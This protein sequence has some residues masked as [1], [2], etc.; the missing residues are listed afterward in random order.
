[1]KHLQEVIDAH[2]YVKTLN[3][4]LNDIGDTAEVIRNVFGTSRDNALYI[5]A[6]LVGKSYG[7]DLSDYWEPLFDGE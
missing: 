5:A 2:E 3:I 4:A 6:E 1:M 7:L